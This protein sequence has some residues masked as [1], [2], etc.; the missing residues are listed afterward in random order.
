M[1]H[2]FTFD[3]ISELKGLLARADIQHI[4]IVFSDLN[5]LR[6]TLKDLDTILTVLSAGVSPGKPEEGVAS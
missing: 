1:I 3:S 5:N 6:S 4:N 2:Y